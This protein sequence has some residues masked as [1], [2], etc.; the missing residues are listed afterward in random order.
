MDKYFDYED[1]DEEKMVKHVVIILKGNKH[2]GGMNYR[3]TE[4][5]KENKRS[6]TGIE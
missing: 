5:A 3:L 6:R 2:Y 4:E 1:V